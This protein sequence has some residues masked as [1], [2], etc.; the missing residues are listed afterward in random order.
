VIE[1]RPGLNAQLDS[2]ELKALAIMTRERVGPDLPTAAES[3]PGLTAIGW[4]GMFAPKGT[5]AA[6]VRQLNANIGRA[7]E[8]P[9][10]KTRLEQIG[11]PYRPLFA[12][13]FARFIEAEQKL[14]WP[15]VRE[16]GLH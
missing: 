6:I 15:V 13:D 3:V 16:A 12:D 8:A 2:G 1:G 14:W 7:L 5:P 4:N 11:T 10:V 9:D